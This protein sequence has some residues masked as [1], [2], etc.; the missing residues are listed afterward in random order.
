MF[1]ERQRE[2]KKN[3]RERGR[4][5]GRKEDERKDGR[6]N[7]E[8][9]KQFLPTLPFCPFGPSG[10]GWPKI[11]GI[12]VDT[13]RI[14][15]PCIPPA[16]WEPGPRSLQYLPRHQRLRTWS[17]REPSLSCGKRDKREKSAIGLWKPPKGATT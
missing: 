6:K 5:G 3:G 14:P 10:P 11:P 4:K 2:G 8:W 1:M 12:P 16:T 17:P 9:K 7:S 13:T 15:Q